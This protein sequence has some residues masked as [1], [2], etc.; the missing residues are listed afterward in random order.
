MRRSLLPSSKNILGYRIVVFDVAAALAA[1]I[2]ALWLR[3]P[4]ALT[5]VDPEPLAI[6]VSAGAC[7]SVCF[8]VLFRVAHGLPRYF[9]FHDAI[10]PCH[11]MMRQRPA[12]SLP[13]RA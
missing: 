5:F 1:P 12:G 7:L 11:M 9:S 13:L 8:F 10:P 4:A 6:Y 3:D 2:V